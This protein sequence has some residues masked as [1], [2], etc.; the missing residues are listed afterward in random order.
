MKALPFIVMQINAEWQITEVAVIKERIMLGISEN[1]DVI[2]KSYNLNLMPL[3]INRQI[4]L[5]V[6]IRNY[7]AFYL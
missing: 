5:A 1:S 7:L 3:V 2:L 6:V 4:T